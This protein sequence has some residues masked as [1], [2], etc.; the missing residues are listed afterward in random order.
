MADLIDIRDHNGII[1]KL[2]RTETPKGMMKARGATNIADIRALIPRSQWQ[3]ISFVKDAP[4]NLIEDQRQYGSCSCATVTGAA[5]RQRWMRGQKYEPLS[6]CWLY[7]QVNGGG[8][9]GSNMGQ[10]SE[11]ARRKGVPPMSSYT[12]CQFHANR[13]PS[14]VQWWREGDPE[15]T[16]SNF[17]Q[18][19]T[20]IL[21]GICVQH[22][23]D[24]NILGSF[25]NNGIARGR[26]RSA[27]HS[28]YAA[29][30]QQVG[31]QWVVE[32]VNSWRTD[33][34]PFGKGY[35]YLTEAQV[36]DVAATDDAVGHLVTLDP[37]AT[38]GMPEPS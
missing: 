1:R 37:S 13:D 32:M 7:D 12:A 19:V 3:P 22:A 8:D 29:G 11:V 15:V 38:Q 30:L 2:G 14:G 4:L 34:G 21:L 5:N 23:I 16:F 26:G 17:E 10:A 18:I 20:G 33:F 35:C 24:A 28:V 36:N 31:G 6:W 25:D 9:N 27:N